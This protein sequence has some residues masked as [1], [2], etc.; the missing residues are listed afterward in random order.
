[1]QKTVEEG[2]DGGRW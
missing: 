2:G 1:M